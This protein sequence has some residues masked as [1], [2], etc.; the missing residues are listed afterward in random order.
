MT[1]IREE[2]DPT[3]RLKLFGNILHRLYGLRT[4]TLCI[5]ILEKK[6]DGVLGNRAG[7]FR[8]E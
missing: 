6:S 7:E 8:I 1:R 4:R 3:Q 5:E 2:E